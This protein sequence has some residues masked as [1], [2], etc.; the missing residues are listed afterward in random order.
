MLILAQGVTG[1][2][3]SWVL[4]VTWINLAGDMGC[5]WN[6]IYK[7]LYFAYTTN[8]WVEDYLRRCKRQAQKLLVKCLNG[9]ECYVHA[10]THAHTHVHLCIL[11]EMNPQQSKWCSH[12]INSSIS[13]LT[14]CT[15]LKTIFKFSLCLW[16][17][18]STIS[19]QFLSQME[20][21]HLSNSTI[22]KKALIGLILVCVIEEAYI[23]PLHIIATTYYLQWPW[24]VYL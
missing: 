13:L 10:H 11:F 9:I 12:V 17:F 24:Q 7:K 15:I 21:T 23:W 6:V 4:V 19:K 2:K 18:R 14:M 22:Q 20:L 5:R 3:P 1:F 8:N 16:N